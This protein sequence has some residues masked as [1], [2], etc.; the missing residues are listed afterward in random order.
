MTAQQIA[1]AAAA[2]YAGCRTYTD[3]GCVR[4]VFL[5]PD[6]AANFVSTKSFR[7]AFVRPE[8]FRFEF[9]SH[10][11]HQTQTDRYI[12]AAEGPRVRTW[13]DVTPGVEEPESLRHALGAAAG[14]SGGS[15][16]TVPSLLTSGR[17]GGGI[18]AAGWYDL[19]RLDDADLDGVPCHR[20]ERRRVPDP[21]EDRRLDEAVVRVT[22]QPAPKVVE[23]PDV[24]WI[25]AGSLLLRRIDGRSDF[26]TFR[27]EEVTTYEP[28]VDGPVR[29]DQLAFD[30]PPDAGR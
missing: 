10:D 30:P 6:G 26:T 28:A 19:A 4:T 5:H 23:K 18:W 25:E 13:W 8:R 22:G 29:D 17:S 7:T 1:A 12:I 16:R 24:F 9:V 15:S 21:E 20:I 2:V 3:R 27:T 14:V 11:P